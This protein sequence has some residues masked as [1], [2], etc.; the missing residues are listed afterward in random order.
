MLRCIP[1][2]AGTV[3]DLGVDGAA[4]ERWM[5]AAT[6]RW[7]GAA[8]ER[9]M[10]AATERWMGAAA[11]VAFDAA[12]CLSILMRKSS[13]HFNDSASDFACVSV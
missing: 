4:T 5:G 12:T 8:T 7:M 6:E 2:G 10:G 11:F 3:V 1:E 13:T 9:W